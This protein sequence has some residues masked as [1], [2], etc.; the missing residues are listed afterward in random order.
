M[1]QADLFAAHLEAQ[2]GEPY[3]LGDE[4][5]HTHDCSGLHYEGMRAAGVLWK[6][7]PWPRETANDYKNKAR[8]IIWEALK[9]GDPIFF[10]G[11]SGHAYHVASY[12]GGGYTIEARGR[13]WGVVKYRVDDPTN[14]V[15][16]RG[17]KPYHYPGI[18]LGE[19]E[20]DMTPEEVR[21]I[22]REE[23]EVVWSDTVDC[24]QKYLVA[25][26]IIEAPRPKGKIASLSYVD[27]LLAR[28]LR[29]AL[30]E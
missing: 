23:L 8:P 17:G 29:K 30:G 28:V 1:S 26:G 22:V 13:R 2:R 11:N 20:D 18:D 5:P 15:K 24:D 25:K 21:Q 16:K 6:G 4:G 12:V 27:S 9:V 14:G 3:V 10:C 7:R 19:L